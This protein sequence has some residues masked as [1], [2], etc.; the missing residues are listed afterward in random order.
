[1]RGGALHNDAEAASSFF[2]LTPLALAA[3][4]ISTSMSLHY[5]AYSL[6][7]PATMTLFT[8]SRLGFGNSRSAYP[9]AMT[10]ISPISLVLLLGYG[11]VLGKLGPLSALKATT[12][13]CASVLLVSGFLIAKLDGMVESHPTAKII[14]K[15]LIGT[16]FVFRESY[17][18]LIT[19]QHWSF[20]SSILTPNQSSRWFA[21]ISGL[22]S[23][24]SAVAAMA[25]GR[26][27]QI[28]GLSGVLVVAGLVLGLSLILGDVA[29]GIAQKNGFNPA[30]E[31]FQ[32]TKNTTTSNHNS[33]GI[34]TKAKDIF[35]RVP[36][37]WALFCEIL[38]CQGLSTLLNVLCVTK[39]SEVITD[40]TERAGWMGQF[41][42]TTNVL[43]SVLQFG[44]LPTTST[45]IEP[46]TLW[47]G[48]PLIM[49]AVTLF[50]ASPKLGTNLATAEPSL[51][52]IA[53]AFQL[54]KTMEFSVRRMLDEMVYVPL[55]YES[56][57]LGKEVIGV[58][59][60]R[61]G[62]SAA[63]L[64]LSA[65]TSSFGVI[66][67]RELS[68][69]TTG[70]AALWMGTAWRLSNLVPTRKEAEEAYK[71]MKKRG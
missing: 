70:A 23:V 26:L 66:G 58:L 25:V 44:I 47:K 46:S 10:F 33:D 41:F 50:L 65:L 22:T 55:D 14:T 48:M 18:Q 5:L 19:S 4:S 63:S 29:Y 17:V 40:D 28:L 45:W 38:A 32:K 39:V 35:T 20:L 8:S 71:K 7:R 11:A 60:Y 6:A 42:A 3:L 16:L 34:I 1:M 69:F 36:T 15:Y 52:A 67:L 57:Y 37:L 68:Y 49:L 56:R 31:H 64:L 61:F 2:Q 27:S 53:L 12:L 43:S 62:K 24:T 51:T 30:D 54:M 9:F 13:G 59:G 21:P